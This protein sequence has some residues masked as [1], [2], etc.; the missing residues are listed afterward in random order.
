MEMILAGLPDFVAG[1][2]IK[3]PWMAQVLVYVG[4]LRILIKPIVAVLQAYVMW[5]PSLEDDSK[6]AAFMEGKL[7]KGI[8]F[9]LDWFASIKLPQKP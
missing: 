4:L 3:A 1:L 6:L 7:Y 5:S 2:L 9:I 8:C